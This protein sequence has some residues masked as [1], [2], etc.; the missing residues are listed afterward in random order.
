MKRL[1][2]VVALVLS[3]MLALGCISPGVFAADE[4]PADFAYTLKWYAYD[5]TTHKIGTG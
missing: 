5:K 1:N 4:T 2:R 3:L